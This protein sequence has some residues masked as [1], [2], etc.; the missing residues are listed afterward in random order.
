MLAEGVGAPTHPFSVL[1][2]FRYLLAANSQ[3]SDIACSASNL[4]DLSAGP[5]AEEDDRQLAPYRSDEFGESE[6]G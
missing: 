6:G 5:A 4:L 1:P 2:E 3:G